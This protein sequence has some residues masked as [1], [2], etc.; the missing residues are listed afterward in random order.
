MKLFRFSIIFL[1]VIM[2]LI[3]ST[4]FAE[5][6]TVPTQPPAE[7]PEPDTSPAPEPTPQI[8]NEHLISIT[9]D[10]VF[11][12]LKLLVES[13]RISLTTDEMGKAELMI[14]YANRR[15]A[16]ADI[17]REQDD[18]ELVRELIRESLKLVDGA[19]AFAFGA[20]EGKGNKHVED[21]QSEISRTESE[22][23]MTIRFGAGEHDDLSQ[24]LGNLE[25]EIVRAMATRTFQT[26]KENFFDAKDDFMTAKEEYKK[27]KQSGDEQAIA[28]AYEVLLAAEANKDNMEE[29]KNQFE[30]LKEKIKDSYEDDEE[31]EKDRD[32]D[33]EEE[34]KKDKDNENKGK[35]KKDK[36]NNG[37]A[38]GKK[39]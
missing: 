19:N 9:P 33:E 37:K 35:G 26:A 25:K 11:Y 28:A 23:M 8:T 36:D 16:E 22:I 3:P 31:E 32:K 20:P 38:K 12:P 10:S 17:M 13:L 30:N 14:S 27:A 34:E 6:S 15:L 1:A 29:I 4:A 21:V 2:V 24:L 5:N 18:E 7:T 39:D